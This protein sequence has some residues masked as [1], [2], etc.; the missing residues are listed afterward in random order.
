MKS[1]FTKSIFVMLIVCSYVVLEGCHKGNN[2]EKISID[3]L[4]IFVKSAQLTKVVGTKNEKDDKGNFGSIIGTLDNSETVKYLSSKKEDIEKSYD[5]IKSY[6]NE[7]NKNS[8]DA[9]YILFFINDQLYRYSLQTI[10]DPCIYFTKI[11]KN[12]TGKLSSWAIDDFFGRYIFKEDPN[13]Q[14]KQMDEDDKLSMIYEVLT[15]PGGIADKCRL[16]SGSHRVK[17]RVVYCAKTHLRTK[18]QFI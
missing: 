1:K 2:F 8:I 9:L 15:I 5:T 3:M 7:D 10:E 12:T 13:N 16:P 4:N 11:N 6:F 14:W 17:S 18:P